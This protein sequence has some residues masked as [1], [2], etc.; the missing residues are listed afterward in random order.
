MAVAEVAL[1]QSGA[2]AQPTPTNAVRW[3]RGYFVVLAAAGLAA[4][5]LGV[6]NRFSSDS[7]F[8][9]PPPVD[10]VPPLSSPQWLQ[11]FA[12]HQ[13]DPVYAACVGTESLSQFKLLYWWEWLRRASVLGLAALGAVGLLGAVLAPRFRF[14]LPRLAVLCALVGGYWLTRALVQFV[15]ANVDVMSQFDD[16]QYDTAVNATF[17]NA[18]LA[19]VLAS[20]VIPPLPFAARIRMSLAMWLWTGFFLLDIALGA[21]CAAKDAAALWWTWPGY[22][23]RAL[24]PLAELLSYSPLWLN[25]TVNPYMLQFLHRALSSGLWLAAL[26]CLFAARRRPQPLRAA[27][28]I[29]ALLTLE[30]ATGI[31]TLVLGVPPELS[32]A[33]QIGG[34]VLLAGTFVALRDDNRPTNTVSAAA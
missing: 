30:M 16:G 11:A 7:L 23:G 6:E 3:V 19:V 24:P 22:E 28:I 26:G 27:A 2:V 21:L 14:V 31:L 15:V 29:F 9:L 8:Y 5:I 13:R 1:S 25:V 34:A 10:F 32:I 12:A 17:A 20:A 18:T 4:S 33:H